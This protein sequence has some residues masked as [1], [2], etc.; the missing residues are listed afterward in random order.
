MNEQKTWWESIR[1]EGG[2]IVGRIR[3]IVHEGNVRRIV[4][5]QQGQTVAEFPLTFGVVGT[6]ISP[7]LAAIGALTALLTDCSIEI[8]RTEKPGPYPDPSQPTGR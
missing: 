2:E 8:E 4:V 6:V 1:V 7:M 5:K 3:R